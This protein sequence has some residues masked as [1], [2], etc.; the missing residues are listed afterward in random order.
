MIHGPSHQRSPRRPLIVSCLLYALLM[1]YASTLIGPAGLNFVYRDPIVALRAF[2]AT[3]YVIHGSDQRADWIGN[4]LMLVPFGFMA[5][6]AGWP[7]RAPWRP[8]A[9][10]GA[11]LFCLVII[12]LIKYLQLFFPPRTVTLNY[13]I[14]Q[15]AGAFIGCCCGVIWKWRIAP[16]IEQPDP[17]ILLIVALRLYAPALFLFILMPL[18]F[19]LDV[20]DLQTQLHR[21]PQTLW[22]WPG[23]DRPPLV[24]AILIGVSSAAFVPVGMLLTFVRRGGYRVSR[25]LPAIAGLGLLL[26]T[27]LYALAAL[28]ISATPA[29]GAVLYRTFGIVAGAAALRWLVRQDA[30]ALRSSLRH[31]VPWLLMPYLVAVLLLNRLLSTHWLSLTQAAAQ[32]YPLGFLPLFD[33][34]IV[35]KAEAAKNIVGHFVLYMPVGAMLWLRCSRPVVLRAF[36]CA[37][38]LSFAV[39]AARYLRPRLEGDINAVV[40]AGLAAALTVRLMPPLWTMLVS[41]RIYPGQPDH[42]ARPAAR[43]TSGPILTLGSQASGESAHQINS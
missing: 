10:A 43:Q 22:A 32:A 33:Y 29:L 15:S 12:L 40:V 19:A 35:T 18:D 21:L 4:L 11:M 7:D 6:A 28:V 23:T 5:V 42:P 14:A 9:V 30:E 13:I 1:L 39:E 38:T 26:T 16:A 20:A 3:P 17:K 25:G 8:V 36:L 24:Q 34:Y 37:A 2:I 27:G 41:L 31:L